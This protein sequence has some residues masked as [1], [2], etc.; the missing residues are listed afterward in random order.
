MQLFMTITAKNIAFSDFFL[1]FADAT[2]IFYHSIYLLLFF[3]RVFVMKFQT[4]RM[5]FKTSLTFQTLLIISETF[6][7]FLFSLPA[8]ITKPFSVSAIVSSPRCSSFFRVFVWHIPIIRDMALIFNFKP[9]LW[10]VGAE[11]NCHSSA[12]NRVLYH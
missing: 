5:V 7:N 10:G 3:V 8:D 12:H 9:Y 4:S 11:S 2:S 1:D 6:S